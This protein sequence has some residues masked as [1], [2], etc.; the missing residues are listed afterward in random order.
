MLFKYKNFRR[1]IKGQNELVK[2]KEILKFNETHK[3]QHYIETPERKRHNNYSSS[4]TINTQVEEKCKTQFNPDENTTKILPKIVNKRSFKKK[5]KKKPKRR[6]AVKQLEQLLDKFSV[7]KENEFTDTTNLQSTSNINIQ[8]NY[9]QPMSGVVED[10]VQSDVNTEFSQS[11]SKS[12]F[13]R[14]APK[15]MDKL[16]QFLSK[17]LFKKSLKVFIFKYFHFVSKTVTL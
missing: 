5:R 17:D 8:Q 7:T 2:R 10:Q 15:L 11:E 16:L 4:L 3:I 6:Q 9:P 14:S 1:I 12:T 13:M